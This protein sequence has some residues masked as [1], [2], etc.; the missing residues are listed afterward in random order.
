M[1]DRLLYGVLFDEGALFYGKVVD[2]IQVDIPDVTWFGDIHTHFPVFNIADSCVTVGVILLLF[3]GN[4]LP[5][6]SNERAAA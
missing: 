3:T 1:I 4:K 6:T 2:F 5:S